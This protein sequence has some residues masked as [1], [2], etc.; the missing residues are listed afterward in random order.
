MGRE[1]VTRV[2]FFSVW[3]RLTIAVLESKR[4][5]IVIEARW[6]FT[7]NKKLAIWDS[8]YVISLLPPFMG[9]V[10]PRMRIAN[11]VIFDWNRRLS[12]KRYEIGT[13]FLWNA[14]RKSYVADQSVSVPMTLSD[15]NPGFKVM[16]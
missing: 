6:K 10:E 14:N 8:K 16:V 1:P 7:V 9:H 12:R 3:K 5:L 15:P 13:W 4:P 11:F 2:D